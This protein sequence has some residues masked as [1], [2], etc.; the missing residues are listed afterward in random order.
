LARWETAHQPTRLRAEPAGPE[1]YEFVE[2]LFTDIAKDYLGFAWRH[3][4]F[5][6]LR[7]VALTDIWI[8]RENTRIVGYTFASADQTMLTISN[9]VLQPGIDAV[10]A[11]SAVAAQLKSAYVQV[12]ASRPIEIASLQRRGYHLTH[13][14][15]DSFMVKPIVPEVTFA[16]AQRLFGIGTDRF[17][18]SWL[19]TT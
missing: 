4:P 5:A 13:P 3:T 15:W 18:I 10:E 14:T 7:R 8:L 1:G 11:I 16:D 9:L 19:D 17:L 6:R 2:N 12:K